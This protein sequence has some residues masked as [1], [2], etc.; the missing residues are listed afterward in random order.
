M[1]ARHKNGTSYDGTAARNTQRQTA[2]SRLGITITNVLD[3]AGRVLQTIRIGTDSSSIQLSGSGYGNEGSLLWET[4]A[5]LGLTSHSQT[6]NGLGET[7]I[8]DTYPDNGTRISTYYQDGSPLSVAGT[9]VAP[10]QYLYGAYSGGTYAV[11]VKLTST[12]GTNEWVNT[13]TD[14]AGRACTNTYAAASSPPT[15]I[16]PT[17]KRT[18]LPTNST[19]TASRPS[20]PIPPRAN[21]PIRPSTWTKTARLASPAQ[22]HHLRHQRRHQRHD[23]GQRRQRPPHPHLGLEHQRQQSRTSSPPSRPPPTVCKAGT[24]SGTAARQR[25]A[26]A[27]PSTPAT[28]TATSPTPP[29]TAP[30]P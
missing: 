17:T 27:P 19:R 23:P 11:Q 28:A 10:L 30:T 16:S 13:S 25:P 26:T 5:L 9:A 4:N 7:V 24:P 21:W 15:S 3:G 12:G 18:S 22:P 8:T 14:M 20:T 1:L 6:L 2:S 29:R